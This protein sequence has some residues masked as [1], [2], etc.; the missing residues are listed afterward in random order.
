MLEQLY[1][2]MNVL[3]LD[4]LQVPVWRDKDWHLLACPTEEQKAHHR[5]GGNSLGQKKDLTK[6]AS[7]QQVLVQAV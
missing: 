3:C 1:T 2:M 6:C 7:P 4:Q 5:R